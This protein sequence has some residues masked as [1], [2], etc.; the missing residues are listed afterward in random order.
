MKLF[1]V[2]AHAGVKGAA[3]QAARDDLFNAVQAVLLHGNR[4]NILDTC[5]ALRLEGAVTKSGEYAANTKGDVLRALV[6]LDHAAQAAQPM[7]RPV[8]KGKATAE[9][10]VRALTVAG[11][12][13]EAFEASVQADTEA[14]K[15][16]RKASKPSPK[17]T[18][19]ATTETGTEAGTE[20][21][22]EAGTG[23]AVKAD[24][25]DPAKL[26]AMIAALVEERD[27]LAEALEAVTA[28][29]DALLQVPARTT[30]PRKARQAV[31]A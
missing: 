21:G 10:A 17:A 9:E 2:L 16:A 20:T 13:I 12:I 25:D 23:T 29:R 24:S 18:T 27:A 19:E 31:A 28:E 30:K 6:A 22:T 11:P 3:A 1:S 4:R 8:L 7:V 26:R 5:E 14:R 15:L